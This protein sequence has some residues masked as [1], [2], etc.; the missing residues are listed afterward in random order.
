MTHSFERPPMTLVTCTP[1]RESSRAIGRMTAVPTPPPT[2]TAWP[3]AIRSV[4]WP[5]GPATSWIASPTWRL[6]SSVVLTPTAWIIRVM[7]PASGSLS[8]IVERDALCAR[9]LPDDDELAG[10]PDLCDPGGLDDEADDV[11]GELLAL[12]D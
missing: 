3:V 11:R 1:R 5:R 12:D 8:A 6:V 2:Q 7:V 9:T 4:S 10:T